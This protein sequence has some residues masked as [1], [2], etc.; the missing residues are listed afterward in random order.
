M[1][2]P[3]PVIVKYFYG[4]F[5]GQVVNHLSYK[6]IREKIGMQCGDY[7]QEHKWVKGKRCRWLW[8]V[9]Y[10]G[11]EIS[12]GFHITGWRPACAGLFSKY[13]VPGFT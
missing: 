1:I 10:E 9:I 6:R 11:E 7:I 13:I 8:Y 4:V 5:M 3:S 12:S 2:P